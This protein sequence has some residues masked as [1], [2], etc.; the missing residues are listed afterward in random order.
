[1]KSLVAAVAVLVAPRIG[2]GVPHGR[3]VP[4]CGSV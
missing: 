3:Q 1:M 4:T 2:L